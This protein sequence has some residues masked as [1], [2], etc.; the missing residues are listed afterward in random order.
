[1]IKILCGLILIAYIVSIITIYNKNK[2]KHEINY[3]MEELLNKYYKLEAKLEST[4]KLIDAADERHKKVLSDYSNQAI[5]KKLE[6]NREYE[7]LEQEKKKTLAAK[8]E[9]YYEGCKAQMRQLQIS[10]DEK[11]LEVEEELMNLDK[12]IAGKQASYEGLIE[13]LKNLEKDKQAKM[14]YCIQIP[15]E[16]END[17]DYLV[18]EVVP[19]VRHPDIISKLI[20]QEY[21]KTPFD[22]TLKRV[23][24]N[25]GP[26][27]YKITNVDTGMC[28]IGKSTN[29][30]KRLQD[31]IKSTIG[32]Q[33]IADQHIH[34]EI[35]KK[36]IHNW[37]FE[38]ICSCE[39]EEL[40]EKEKFYIEKFDSQN[41]G[42]N[43]R[44]GG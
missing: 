30:K 19:K 35:L 37:M 5:Q 16:D 14:F 31:H 21:I 34:H 12:L 6:L 42:Y 25:D 39:K 29:V 33:S 36:G 9:N 2:K 28:Y 22:A 4:E 44:A 11:R 24:V 23:G 40:N 1:M 43:L 41:Y 3:S 18:R 32:I 17:I 20:W 7:E 26:G 8:V 10:V 38:Q 13:P 27:I 15:E